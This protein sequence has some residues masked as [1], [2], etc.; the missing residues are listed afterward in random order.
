MNRI[1]HSVRRYATFIK[2]SF[3]D[4]E[5]RIVN[6]DNI[7]FLRLNGSCL[8]FCKRVDDGIFSDSRY[9]R[10][11]YK[12]AEEAAAMFEKVNAFLEANNK[13]VSIDSR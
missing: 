2:S 1:S 12:N 9:F 10:I 13:I 11:N 7:D 5:R 4:G 3:S 8:T 6:L